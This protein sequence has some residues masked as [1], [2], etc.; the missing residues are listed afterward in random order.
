MISGT[1]DLGDA[2]RNKLEGL[3]KTAATKARKGINPFTGEERPFSQDLIDLLEIDLR[4]DIPG[5][6]LA[7]G[8]GIF[9]NTNAQYSR[10]SEV[11]RHY[12]G[13]TFANV[14]VEHKDV[15]G[16]T[17]RAVWGNVL[18]AR[19]K[20]DRTVFDGPRP[21]SDVLFN[22]NMDRRIGPIF[23]FSVSGDF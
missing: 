10:L 5:S 13:P 12:E 17:M 18:S 7:Y 15:F 22:E 8:A 9:T 23:R 16:L 11:G 1:K 21:N 19:N 4:H 2:D 20:F 14:F 6:S 3:V